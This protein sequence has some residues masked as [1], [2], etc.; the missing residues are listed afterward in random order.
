MKNRKLAALDKAQVELYN[1]VH[2][3]EESGRI[4]SEEHDKLLTLISHVEGEI[5]EF[6]SN[7]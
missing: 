2:W 4:T 7:Q 5:F 1:Y 6:V 3:C